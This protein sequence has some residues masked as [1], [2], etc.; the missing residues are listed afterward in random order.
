MVSQ[1]RIFMGGTMI[2]KKL[3]KIIVC[4]MVLVFFAASAA[5]CQVK[6]TAD[7]DTPG[8]H[9]QRGV[10]FFKKGFSE[11]APR[12]QAAQ[13]ELNYRLA[14][15]EFKA[16]IEKDPSYTDAH[17]NLAR[18]YFVKKNFEEAA[19][20]YKKVTELAPGDL[21]SYVNLA[22]AYIELKEFEEAVEALE[23]AKDRTSDPRVLETLNGYIARIRAREL[24]GMR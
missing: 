7:T 4:A 21:D 15:K 9:N 3:R 11:Y 13:A 6:G 23:N 16:A 22:L 19:W 10:E 20:E 8:T 5:L 14:I 1:G 18:V 24:K 2:S 17:R 12:N